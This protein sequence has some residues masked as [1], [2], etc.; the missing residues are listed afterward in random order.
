MH[1]TDIYMFH[2]HTVYNLSI[3]RYLSLEKFIPNSHMYSRNFVCFLLVP[4]VSISSS[5][6]CTINVQCPPVS[7]LFVHWLLSLTNQV[8]C[9]C[10]MQ[11]DVTHQIC[12]SKYFKVSYWLLTAMHC[13]FWGDMIGC[14]FCIKEVM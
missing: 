1:H 11:S 6:V 2:H 12:P 14:C 3:L 4:Q 7:V 13:L 10:G 8:V 5:I 9:I